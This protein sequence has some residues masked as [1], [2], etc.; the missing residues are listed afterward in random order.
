MPIIN[1]EFKNFQCIIYLLYNIKLS[2]NSEFPDSK[3][4]VEFW[5]LVQVVSSKNL[6]N[7]IYKMVITKFK[8][9]SL[10]FKFNIF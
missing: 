7:L 4:S 3:E 10:T 5:N 2:F 8:K 6:I 9:V 1:L